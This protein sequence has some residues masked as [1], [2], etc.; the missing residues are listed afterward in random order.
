MIVESEAHMEQQ[1]NDMYSKP[2]QRPGR[3][4]F[5]LWGPL[6]IKYG[7][8]YLVTIVFA[9]VMVR[10]QFMTNGA[11]SEEALEAAMSTEAGMNQIFNMILEE[12]MPYLV[13]LDGVAAALTIPVMIFMFHRDRVREKIAG[14]V[15]NKKAELWKYSAI[16]GISAAL[17]VALN[18]LIY[19]SGL[20]P[21]DATYQAMMELMYSAPF[22]VQ[23]ICL[24]IL[25]PVCEELVF[26]GLI[27]KRFRAQTG[28][29]RSALISTFVFAF[30]HGN[31]IQMLYAFIMGMI[32]A[33]VYEKYGSVK[34]P[35]VAHIAANMISLICTEF[36]SFEWM[37]EETMRINL[38]TIACAAFAATMYV[39][40]QR[41]EEKP[42]VEENIDD[43]E[44]NEEPTAM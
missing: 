8:A 39:L 37:L 43:N 26:R 13:I 19:L 32:F 40:I 31:M 36:N 28:F 1:Y 15:P 44:M 5:Y 11:V 3:G 20:L 33:Y 23:I 30:I 22:W 9:Y 38:I 2:K 16:I 34:A 25:A 6:L 24:G 42:E 7:I 12:S 4:F 41:I 14:I 21:M 27:F 10:T 17:C 29:V 35:I 18:C